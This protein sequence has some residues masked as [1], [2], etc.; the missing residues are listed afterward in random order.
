M[1]G[2]IEDVG[3]KHNQTPISFER[4]PREIVDGF[5]RQSFDDVI[6]GRYEDFPF[7]L[8]EATLVA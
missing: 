8:Y 1:F 6:S 5:N 7:E 2:F 4:L 3:Y